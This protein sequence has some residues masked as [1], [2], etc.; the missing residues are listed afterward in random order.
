MRSA[1]AS[2]RCFAASSLR[3]P[4]ACSVCGLIL[5]GLRPGWSLRDSYFE[6][7]FVPKSSFVFQLCF[8]R[9]QAKM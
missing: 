2:G 9:K 1:F 7:D 8:H 4:P 6:S 3:A 5:M